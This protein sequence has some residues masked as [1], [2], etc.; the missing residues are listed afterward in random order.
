MPGCSTT[1]PNKAVA[2]VPAAAAPQVTAVAEEPHWPPFP[3]HT[4]DPP[5]PRT[6]TPPPQETH[7]RH[8]LRDLVRVS[9]VG[10]GDEHLNLERLEVGGVLVAAEEVGVQ[11]HS[12]K[13]GQAVLVS[14]CSLGSCM[15]KARP[16]QA[17]LVSIAFLNVF[18]NCAVGIAGAAGMWRGRPLCM[19]GAGVGVGYPWRASTPFRG[20]LQRP[21]GGAARGAAGEGRCSSGLNSGFKGAAVPAPPV[22]PSTDPSF[23]PS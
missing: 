1:L 7:L 22:Q 3:P 19:G 21:L 20:P 17:I 12:A 16:G 6:H 14:I 23:L 2:V 8:L 9:S 4:H 13:Q 11:L 10:D 5:P 15:H 18:C